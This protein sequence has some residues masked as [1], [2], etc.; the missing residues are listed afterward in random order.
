[1]SFVFYLLYKACYWRETTITEINLHQKDR[2]RHQPWLAVPERQSAV[3]KRH[4]VRNGNQ[5]VCRLAGG[6]IITD[7]AG[8]T[9]PVVSVRPSDVVGVVSWRFEASMWTVGGIA[10][11]TAESFVVSGDPRALRAVVLV[12]RP[13]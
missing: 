1:M 2:Q 12:L 10:S 8:G 13:C 3:L 4:C 6:G 9:C 5:V 7:S 11:L